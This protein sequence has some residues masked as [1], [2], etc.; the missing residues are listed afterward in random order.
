MSVNGFFDFFIFPLSFPSYTDCVLQHSQGL[1]SIRITKVA[2]LLGNEIFSAFPNGVSNIVELV[3]GVRKNV[4]LSRKFFHPC[5][6]YLKWTLPKI[7]KWTFWGA[8]VRMNSAKWD[9]KYQSFKNIKFILVALIFNALKSFFQTWL[10][11][12]DE[13]CAKL[14]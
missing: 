1:D 5:T 14:R 11:W 2:I 4:N 3:S 12:I 13:K 10:C 7:M 6:Q 9:D 8:Y